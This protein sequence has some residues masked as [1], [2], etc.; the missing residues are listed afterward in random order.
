VNEREPQ[1][2]LF[3]AGRPTPAAHTPAPAVAGRSTSVLSGQQI[4]E[5]MPDLRRKVF[6]FIRDAGSRGATDD[7]IQ[8]ALG[9]NPSTQR[10]RRVE[11]ETQGFVR[12][13]PED[14]TR[15][16]RSGRQAVVWVM[17]PEGER[18]AVGERRQVEAEVTGALHHFIAAM[19]LEQRRAALGVL[20]AR[21]PGVRT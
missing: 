13:H 18:V 7:E 20:R 15:E 4:V 14:L 8:H 16:T 6:A 9:L 5:A 1:L 10:P 3:G 2:D 11:L 17:V 12:A 21:F 19:D